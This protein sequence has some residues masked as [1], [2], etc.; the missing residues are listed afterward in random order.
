[1]ALFALQGVVG[2]N[3]VPNGG[4]VTVQASSGGDR[5][6]LTNIEEISPIAGARGDRT[7][8]AASSLLGFCRQCLSADLVIID[9]DHARVY[10]AA[11][12]RPWL[13][14]RLISVD[15]ILRQ[16]VS[17]RERA[18]AKLKTLALA[19]VDKFIF[20]FKNTA[21][22]ESWYGLRPERVVYVPFKPNGKD[23][24][25]W[26]D[27]VP[28]GDYVLCA[29][30]TMRDLGTFVKAM[31]KTGYPAVLLQQPAEI[32]REHGTDDWRE[33]LPP[34]VKLVVHEDGKLETFLSFIAKAKLVVIPRYKRD[35]GCTGISTYL[36]A[37]A[38]G[39]CVVISDGPGVGDLLKDEAAIVPAEDAEPLAATVSRLWDDDIERWQIATCGKQYADSVGGTERLCGD[40]L[41]QSLLCLESAQAFQPTE[42]AKPG[43]VDIG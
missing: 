5:V 27:T 22:Y 15:L 2:R 1:V 11:L 17:L 34:N 9:N 31:A 21:G 28:E 10:V 20:Y 32:M 6:I 29:G 25:F 13:P 3:F 7:V 24:L 40:I 43:C 39:K 26:P 36:M 38:L 8:M 42:K 41:A 33:E 19:Q 23:E 12:L 30:R 37:M 16:P 35:I 4:S 14:F 18:L